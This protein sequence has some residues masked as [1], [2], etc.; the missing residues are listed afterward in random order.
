MIGDG[1]W[2][3]DRRRRRT[4]VCLFFSPTSDDLSR[5]KLRYGPRTASLFSWC[6]GVVQAL[7]V[8]DTPVKRHRG[9][10][11]GAT[12]TGGDKRP[13]KWRRGARNEWKFSGGFSFGV[14]NDG[15]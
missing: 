13:P 4:E 15:R 3:P 8:P 2:E 14:S 11:F 7:H 1:V 12:G 9:W 6:E 5:T 10:A